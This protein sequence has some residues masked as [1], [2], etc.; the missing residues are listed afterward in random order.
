MHPDG[1]RLFVSEHAGF[2]PLTFLPTGTPASVNVYNTADGSL[3]GPLSDTADGTDPSTAIE[4][5]TGL[6]I[7]AGSAAALTPQQ[8]IEAVIS[9]LAL[10]IG[11]NPDSDAADKIE[12]VIDK[13]RDALEELDEEPPI[14]K[15]NVVG[16]LEGAVGDL[17]A[18]VKDGLLGA[19]EGTA[20]L[21][22]LTG[23]ARQL[24]ADALAEAIAQGGDPGDI[25]DAQEAL[26]EGDALRASGDFKDAVNKYKDALSKAESAIN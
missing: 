24:A 17:E 8:Q 25:A 9:D 15:D 5:P 4:A 16:H 1:T 23:V 20:L 12:D 11:G 18:A 7:V 14:D 13:L 22:Q 3:I 26:D 21:D 10:I 6:C 19:A 2:D